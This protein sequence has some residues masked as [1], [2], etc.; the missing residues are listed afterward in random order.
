MN[1]VALADSLLVSGS[2]YGTFRAYRVTSTGPAQGW[3]M[4]QHD[5]RRSGRAE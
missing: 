3:P 2:S 4:F 5:A 1:H